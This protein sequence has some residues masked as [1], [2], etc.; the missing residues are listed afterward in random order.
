MYNTSVYFILLLIAYTTYTTMNNTVTNDK[1]NKTKYDAVIIL[2]GGLTDEGQPHPFVQERIRVGSL[3]VNETEYF[4]LCSRGTTHKPPPRDSNGFSLDESVISTRQ[5]LTLLPTLDANKC[6]LDRWSLDTIGNA[7]FALTSFVEP[8]ELTRVCVVTSLFHMPRSEAI[9]RHV[10]S[11]SSQ[12]KIELTFVSADDIGINPDLLQLR[13]DKEAKSL[14]NW[15]QTMER[16]T[17]KLALAQFLFTEHG[18][19]NGAST[20]PL[21]SVG[22]SNL[23]SEE[24]KKSY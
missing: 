12:K 10:F 14:E 18:A 13:Q 5:L 17:T 9:F 4:I 21:T 6:L 15:Y 2:G 1:N 19:Y 22:T 3:L 20:A 23:V 8:L 16:C 24:V 7:W 11:L